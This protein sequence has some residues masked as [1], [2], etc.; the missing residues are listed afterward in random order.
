MLIDMNYKNIKSWII[1]KC[2]EHVNESSVDT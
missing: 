2:R 1:K